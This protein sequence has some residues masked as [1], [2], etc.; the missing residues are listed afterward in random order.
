MDSSKKRRPGMIDTKRI[1][2]GKVARE[3]RVLCYGGDGVGKTRFAA[4]APDPFFLDVNR[5]SLEYDVKRVIPET[6]SETLEWI[7]AVERGVVNC[8]TL[9]IDS[10]SDLEHMGNM[11]FFPNSTID[12]WDGGYGRGETYALTRW[13]EML[14]ALERVWISGKAIILIGHMTVK[15]FDDP[16]QVGYDRYELAA[17]QKI[18]GALRQWVDYVLF[19]K[20]HLDHQKIARDEVR[21][22]TNGSRWLHTQ[23]SPAF[24]AKS[25]GTTLFPE[26]V[27]LSWDEFAKARAADAARVDELKREIDSMLKEIGDKRLDEMVREYLRANPGMV[28]EARNRVA[29]RL[30]EVRAAAKPAQQQ[31]VA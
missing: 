4:G 18:A 6:W 8:K 12:K 11:E 20:E 16:T 3:P 22:V 30:E 1:T 21:P 5:G 31:A 10:V 27:L 15:H 2:A 13:R 25:R 28:V 26:R 19:A 9:V 29:A 7:G 23:R 17:R 14:S 24:D